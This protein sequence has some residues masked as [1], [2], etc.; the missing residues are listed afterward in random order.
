MTARRRAVAFWLAVGGAGFLLLPW[1]AV[2][3]SVLG[4][5][6][7]VD[8]TGRDHAPALWQAVRHGRA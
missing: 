8:W 1:Y 3:G 7:L 5:A 4:T 2:P 6:W